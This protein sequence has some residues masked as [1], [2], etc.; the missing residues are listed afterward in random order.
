MHVE[1]FMAETVL[2]AAVTAV[3]QGGWELRQTLD[4][5]P[6][7]IYVTD[8]DGVVTYFNR[9]CVGFAGRTPRLG[10]DRWCITWKLYTEDGD[11]LPHADCPM[12]VAIQQRRPVRGVEAIA[13]RPDGGR[14]SFLPYPTPL[15]DGDG[16]LTSAVNVLIDVTDSP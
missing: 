14:A 3:Q 2:R 15:F 9:A 16:N 6:V 10:Q 11:L 4:T 1:R 12:A 7:P 5:L 8:P 13:E